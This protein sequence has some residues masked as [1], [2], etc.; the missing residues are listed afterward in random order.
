MSLI[1]NNPG[2]IRPGEDYAG[3][4]GEFYT[5]LDGSKYVIF[6]SPE[7]GLRALFVDL[8]SKITQFNGD[9]DQIVNKYAP[10]TDGNPTT[11]YASFVKNKMGK[12]V[13]TEADLPDLVFAFVSFENKKSV[14]SQYLKPNLLQT[15]RN[16]LLLY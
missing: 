8:R 6:D 4:T 11:K 14:A 10:P 16:C 1:Y 9:I 3:E 15:G 7:M 13:V 5:A 2:N 12:D